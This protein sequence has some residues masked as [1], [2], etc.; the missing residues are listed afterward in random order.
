[1]V[2]FECVSLVVPRA[3]LEAVE[4]ALAAAP[5]QGFSPLAA[6]L[7][8]AFRAHEAQRATVTTLLEPTRRAE[9]AEAMADLPV[10]RAAFEAVPDV[11]RAAMLVDVGRCSARRAALVRLS[12]PAVVIDGTTAALAEAVHGLDPALPYDPAP[13][14]RVP[15]TDLEDGRVRPNLHAWLELVLQHVREQ[16]SIEVQGRLAEAPA[17]GAPD[18]TMR[19]DIESTCFGMRPLR[20]WWLPRAITLPRQIDHGRTVAGFAGG[21][22]TWATGD[23]PAP[24]G[25]E[26]ALAQRLAALGPDQALVS[27]LAMDTGVDVPWADR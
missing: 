13:V 2:P 17:E 16:G 5:T 1:M 15:E 27:F 9:L 4:A 6:V 23:D 3:A 20:S 25:V 26:A 11:V 12:A 24:S 21:P 22:V 19:P 10:L 14:P 7:G 18:P 8:A